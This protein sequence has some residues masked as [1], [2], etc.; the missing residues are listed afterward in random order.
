MCDADLMAD[1]TRTV[2]LN[3]REYQTFPLLVCPECGEQTQPHDGTCRT[4]GC[5]W[6]TAERYEQGPWSEWGD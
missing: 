3:D 1:T 5:T 4:C 6:E 2:W